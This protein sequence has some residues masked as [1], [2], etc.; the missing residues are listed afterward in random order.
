MKLSEY[1][2]DIAMCILSVGMLTIIVWALITTRAGDELTPP[3]TAN[4]GLGLADGEPLKDMTGSCSLALAVNRPS[5]TWTFSVYATRY[6]G[7]T[8]ADGSIYDHDGFT[9]ASN[10]H[11]FGTQLHIIANGRCV[12]V[13]VTDRLDRMLGKTRI[14]LSG[15][16]MQRLDTNY[17]GTDRT[18]GLLRG[19]AQEVNK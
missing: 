6:H 18:A 14:D 1:A 11:A 4:T 5:Q 17:D 2:F 8:A 13:E 3:V 15:A 19:T 7:R 9:C 16:A 12:M 10:N